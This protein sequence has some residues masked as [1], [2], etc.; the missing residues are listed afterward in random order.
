VSTTLLARLLRVQRATAAHVAQDIPRR[1][2]DSKRPDTLR[3]YV[4][5]A[6]R[7]ESQDK[8]WN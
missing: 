6:L 5:R 8:R 3:R 2:Y 7:E 1:A 4:V